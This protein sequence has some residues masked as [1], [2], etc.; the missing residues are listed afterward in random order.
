MLNKTKVKWAWFS[1]LFKTKQ[2]QLDYGATWSPSPDNPRCQECQLCSQT[3][4]P[5][6]FPKLAG[7]A[8]FVVSAP[9]EDESYDSSVSDSGGRERTILAK[10]VMGKLGFKSQDFS[11]VPA[12]FCRPPTGKVLTKH[13]QM[14]RPFVHHLVK[15]IKGPRRIVAMGVEAATQMLQTSVT[16]KERIGET[17]S[18]PLGEV[19]VT[20]SPGSVL[21][22]DLDDGG[23]K[24][25]MLDV[26][27]CHVERFVTRE[28]NKEFPNLE[29]K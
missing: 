23:Y 14:C 19:T 17:V 22:P 25:G 6:T 1:T 13:L 28:P 8:V 27:R 7:N 29:V 20:Y 3:Y 2:E 16:L 21:V 9:T 10:Y 18:T 11:I 24:M 4:Y 15:R 26:I 5:F 12:V